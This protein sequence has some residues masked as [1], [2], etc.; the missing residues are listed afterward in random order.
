MVDNPTT[1]YGWIMPGD[2]VN[3]NTWGA[4]LNTDIQ[5]IDTTVFAHTQ[6]LGRLSGG[7]LNSVTL[8]KDPS[9]AGV[10]FNGVVGTAKARW[11]I[12]IDGGTESGSNGNSNLFIQRYDDNGA[13]IDSPM[14]FYRNSGA[15]L[16]SNSVTVA[17]GFTAQGGIVSQASGSGYASFGLN[18][19]AGVGMGLLYWDPANQIVLQ[20]QTGGGYISIEP[21]G[22]V[23]ISG[24]LHTSGSSTFASL[25]VS[26]AITSGTVNAS[27]NISTTGQLICGGTVQSIGYQCRQGISGGFSG[28]AFN[29][30]YVSGTGHTQWYIDGAYQGDLAYQAPSDYRIKKNVAPLPTMW[31]RVMALNPISYTHEEFT[32]PN[33]PANPD[34]SP[35][36]EDD[37]KERWGFIA[38]ELQETLIADAAT[39]VKDDPAILQAPNPWTVIATLT[40]ALQEAMA[41]IEALEARA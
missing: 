13:Y 19:N 41:R 22:S 34:G 16:F 26:G 28:N 9:G 10:V 37:G 12:E 35:W 18:N 38:H 11:A 3:T 32:P 33:V 15:V 36:I 4:I 29:A 23:T 14:A 17:K 7:A 40:R 21:D 24:A 6:G 8:Q 1:N 2:H 39:G 30:Y 5:G 31:D 27:G 20:N 25:T